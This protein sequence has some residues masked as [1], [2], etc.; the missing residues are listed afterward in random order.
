[1]I[2]EHRCS[3]CEHNVTDDSEHETLCV[4]HVALVMKKIR[5]RFMMEKCEEDTD[6]DPSLHFAWT[7]FGEEHFKSRNWE[8]EDG[9][10]PD[11]RSKNLDEIYKKHKQNDEIFFNYVKV[12]ADV[13]KACEDCLVREL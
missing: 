10:S 3:I 4:K 1:M 6:W 12:W 9:I 8:V 2:R 5:Q 7:R 11:E 13:V